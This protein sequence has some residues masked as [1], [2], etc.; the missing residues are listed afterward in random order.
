M[1]HRVVVLDTETTGLEPSKGHRIIEIGC[2][3][4]IN[5]RITEN[6]YHQFIQPDREIDEGAFEVHGISTE[7]LA[8]KPRFADVVEDF[9]AF[10]N[11]AELV[12]HNAPFDVGFINH[13]FDKL[14]PV[15]GGVADHCKITDSLVMARKKHPGQKNNLD[16]LCK[17]YT[18]NNARRELH[19]ALLDAELLAEVYLLMT[20]GQENLFQSAQSGDGASSVNISPISRVDKNRPAMKVIR[21]SVDELKAHQENLQ[22]LGEDCIWKQS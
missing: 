2:V 16:A 1:L 20:G 19:G 12:I 8:D 10:I 15:W 21:A 22:K 6:T 9:M 5:R 14:E 11:G 4:I 3:E 17:R 7:F 13:E 18:V